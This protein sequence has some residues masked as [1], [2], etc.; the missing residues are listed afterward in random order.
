MAKDPRKDSVKKA[1]RTNQRQQLLDS[2]PVPLQVL[3][4]LFDRLDQELASGCDHTLRIT[5]KFLQERSIDVTGMTAW[6]RLHGG[7]C[8]CEVIANVESTVGD[9]IAQ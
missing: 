4:G 2:I 7:Y 3:R 9:I 8:D 5:T 1:W 6:L